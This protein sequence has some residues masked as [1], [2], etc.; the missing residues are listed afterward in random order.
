M[1]RSGQT[2][3]EMKIARLREQGAG[4]GKGKA[5]KPWLTV[6]LVASKG[7]SHRPMGR[8]TGRVHHFLSDIERRAFL[9]YDWAQNVSDIR[10]QF[11]LDRVATQRIAGEMGVRH[12]TYPG[13]SVP[14]VMTT[15]FL[16][17]V[18][19]DGRPMLAARAVKPAADLDDA[20]TLEKLE[21]ER[22][23]WAEQ[24][25][26][27]GIVT[28]RDLPPV[29]I[30]NLEWLQGPWADPDWSEEAAT[31]SERL[32]QALPDFSSD[33][34]RDFC[35]AMDAELG[36]PTGETLSL[37]RRLLATR[38]WRADLGVA[39]WTPDLRMEAFVV[40]G[41]EQRKATA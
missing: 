26:S 21:I 12:P 22:R 31:L 33:S 1:A 32:G 19:V 37:V 13:G 30:A 38:R 23:Y 14:V 10:E 8:T 16:L 29:L 5:Y 9:I 35:G 28:E 3:D 18:V 20:R 27:W 24:E 4:A 6:R 7:R 25:I 15:D 17:D 2:W 41:A 36:L 34:L 39:L 11:P 40:E